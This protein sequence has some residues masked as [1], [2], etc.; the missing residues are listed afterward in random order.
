MDLP[1]ELKFSAIF[2]QGGA[3]KANLGEP[4]KKRY[5][6]VLNKNPQH[7]DLIILSTSTTAYALHR[8]CQGGDKV[9]IPLSPSDY[10]DFTENCLICCERPVRTPKNKLRKILNSQNYEILPPLPQSVLDKILNGIRKSSTVSPKEKQ[11]ILGCE[12]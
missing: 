4:S 8:N 11:L 3:F 6:F 9:H 7:D 1:E 12:E 5:Y 2:T 10:S